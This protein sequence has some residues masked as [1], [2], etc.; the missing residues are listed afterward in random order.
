[1]EVSPVGATVAG[2]ANTN[3]YLLTLPQL[4]SAKKKLGVVAASFDPN[5]YSMSGF[6]VETLDPSQF[7][8]QL[9]R[10][11]FINVTDAELGALVVLFDR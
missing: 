7:R 11:F 8:E 3:P 5:F 6:D 10:N 4:I 9:R 1:L 2:M